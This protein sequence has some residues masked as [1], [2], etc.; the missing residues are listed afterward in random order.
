MGGMKEKYRITEPPVVHVMHSWDEKQRILSYIYNET[1]IISVWIP[2]GV[3]VFYRKYSDGNIQSTPFIQQNFI[4]TDKPVK[5]KVLFRLLGQAINIKPHRATTDQAIL[6]QLGEPLIWGVNG[7]YDV[8]QDMLIDWHGAE[9]RWLK[10]QIDR[11]EAGNSTAEMEVMLGS[12]PWIIN[13][14]MQYYRKHL[15][16]AYHK[17]WEWRPNLKPVAGWCSWE[18]YRTDI[19]EDDVRRTVDFLADNLKGYGLEY[20]QIDDGFQLSPVP[21]EGK[22]LVADAWINTNSKF[23]NGHEGMVSHIKSKGMKPGIW[24]NA[25]VTNPEFA[26]QGECLIDT[27]GQPLKGVWIGFVLNC[28]EGV[29]DKHVSPY[30]KRLKE[31]GY[32]YFKTDAIRHLFYDGL[33]QAVCKGLITNDDAEQRFR[34]FLQCARESIG[35]DAYLLACWGVLTEAVGLADACRIATDSNPSWPAICMQ[36]VESARWFHTQRI[37]FLNDPDHVCVRTELEWARSVLSLVSL[38][39]S[40]FMISDP[41]QEYD[42][43]RLRMIQQCLPPLGTTTAE[44]GPL[45]ISYS[46][47]PR[48]ID[49][50][51]ELDVPRGKYPF[52]TLW[53]VHINSHGKS[54]CVMGRFAVVPLEACSVNLEDLGLNP[55]LDYHVFDFWEQKYLGRKSETIDCRALNLGHCQIL[56]L[57]KVEEHP[58]LIASSRHISM[59]A[60][61]VI[62]EIWNENVLTIELTGIVDSCEDYWIYI[63]ESYALINVNSLNG[64]VSWNHKG[65]V[66]QIHVRFTEERELIRIYFEPGCNLPR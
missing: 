9:W 23:P 48:G 18:A 39:G 42:E 57:R 62:S 58:Q 6:G 14:R 56:G 37:L 26:K 51:I 30:Y 11:D 29:L 8:E 19:N 3:N 41:V 25:V 60:V 16:Y 17:P 44:T 22:E 45:D 47:F 4:I 34:R 32:S 59:D 24:T 28:E 63:P 2:D 50:K 13:F 64:N 61:S 65:D 53:A 1:A 21:P 46:A 49:G 35:E 15:N 66:V 5:A 43:A 7:L 52:S 12:A 33:R 38:S 27:D 31:I 36:I 55:D 20:I 40:L 10:T 54:W